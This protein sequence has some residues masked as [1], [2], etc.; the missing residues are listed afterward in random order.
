ML[1]SFIRFREPLSDLELPYHH[2]LVRMGRVHPNIP[3]LKMREA[4]SWIKR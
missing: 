1:F 2:L 4:D 3:C